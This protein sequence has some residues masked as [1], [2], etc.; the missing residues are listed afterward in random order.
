MHVQISVD[1]DIDKE[2]YELIQIAMLWIS[3]LGMNANN[4]GFA[5]RLL[6]NYA[7]FTSLGHSH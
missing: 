6:I 2:A 4:N 5:H 7:Q 1:A 3:E